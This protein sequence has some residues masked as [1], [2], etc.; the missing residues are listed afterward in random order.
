MLAVHD[1]LPV[2]KD[3]RELEVPSH[4]SPFP[5]RSPCNCDFHS[6]RAL[7][8]LRGTVGDPFDPSGHSA[9][10]ADISVVVN[11]WL[12]S[13]AE[14]PVKSETGP[15]HSRPGEPEGRGRFNEQR[16]EHEACLRGG[17]PHS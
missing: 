1:Q 14:S 12:G 9:K 4:P 3:L 2:K 11:D 17:G 7:V 8:V 6:S 13:S 16:N 15:G 10:S 5:A